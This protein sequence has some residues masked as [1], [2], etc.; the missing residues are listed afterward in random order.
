MDRS[1]VVTGGGTG[2]GRAIFDRLLADGWNVV[3]LDMNDDLAATPR[4]APASGDFVVG[5]VAD[6]ADL[7]EAADRAQRLA[8]LAAG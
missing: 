4:G 3:G 6:P 7:E 1:V 8:P 2:I 5:D